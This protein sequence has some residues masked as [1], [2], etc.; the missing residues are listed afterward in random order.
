MHDNP[1]IEMRPSGF[2]NDP[3]QIARNDQMVAIN[4]ALAVDLTGQVAADTL[5]SMDLAA[6]QE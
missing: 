4:S 1:Q 2:T 5:A 3:F 6:V